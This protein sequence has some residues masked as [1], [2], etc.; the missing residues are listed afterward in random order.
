[1]DVDIQ[2]LPLYP[3][4]DRTGRETRVGDRVSVAMWPAVYSSSRSSKQTFR[5]TVGLSDRSWSQ[6]GS[7]EPR[8][9]AYTFIGEDGT[10]YSLS[11]RNFTR[12]QANEAMDSLTDRLLEKAFYTMGYMVNDTVYCWHCVYIKFPECAGHYVDTVLKMEGYDVKGLTP[13]RSNDPIMKMVC[14]VCG[15]ALGAV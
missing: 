1:M 9:R 8:F 7:N 2:S 12:L 15:K 5:G 13:S 4:F 3:L 14:A 10:T 11:N 6:F